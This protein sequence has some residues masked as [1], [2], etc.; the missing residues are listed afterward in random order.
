MTRK[1]THDAYNNNARDNDDNDDDERENVEREN[2]YVDYDD[3]QKRERRASRD[4]YDATQRTIN[5]IRA[6][7]TRDAI[8]RA[9]VAL[10]TLNDTSGARD[11]LRMILLQ[12]S[13]C[14]T[15]DARLLCEQIDII[16]F[17]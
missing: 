14:D 7:D 1:T 10:S 6:I 2:A 9:C 12:C 11:T 15:H 5:V 13:S 3:A 4:E 8:E 16:V 17:G